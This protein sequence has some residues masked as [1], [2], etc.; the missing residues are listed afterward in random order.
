MGYTHFHLA[1]RGGNKGLPDRHENDFRRANHMTNKL[2]A[3]SLIAHAAI[4]A[5]EDG[6]LRHEE[7]R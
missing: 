3:T 4:D 7:E 5:L 1:R 2:S 6:R